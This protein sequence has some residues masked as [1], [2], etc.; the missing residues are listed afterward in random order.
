MDI[1][2]FT[3]TVLNTIILKSKLKDS[4]QFNLFTNNLFHFTVIP[5]SLVSLL[6]SLFFICGI[7]T[8]KIESKTTPINT[9]LKLSLTIGILPKKYPPP[10]YT[11]IHGTD[12]IISSTIN[13][14]YS[15]LAIPATNGT[16][17]RTKGISLESITALFPFLL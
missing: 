15:I 1:A 8:G 2:K 16:N 5:C 13:L 10:T 6:F 7:K 14:E 11:S 9:K 3:K 17:V 4:I 12:P